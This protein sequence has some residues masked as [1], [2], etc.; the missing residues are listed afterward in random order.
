VVTTVSDEKEVER[1][2]TI[3]VRELEKL[4][5]TG[6]GGHGWGGG[7]GWGRG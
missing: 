5:P 3:E 2:E 4:E 1:K 7:G 6:G